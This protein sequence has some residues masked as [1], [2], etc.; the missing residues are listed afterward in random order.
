MK[1]RTNNKLHCVPLF[2][3]FAAIAFSAFLTGCTAKNGGAPGMD[4]TSSSA[5]MGTA[6]RGKYLVTTTGCNDCHTPWTMGPKG[7]GPDM[8]KMLSGHPAGLKMISAPGLQPPWMVAGGMT[9]TSW[10]GPWGIS[11]TANITPDSATGIG[12]WTQDQFISTLKTGKHMGTGRAILPPMP[13]N[14]FSQMTDADLASIYMYLK[15]IPA[16]SNQVPDP[17][18]PSMA[19]Q[20]MP[21]GMQQPPVPPGGMVPPPPP[22]LPNAPVHPQHK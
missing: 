22:P 5:A 20:G 1:I 7:P 16:I 3:A 14:W 4:S 9:M 13:W 19:M 18:P 15:T 2:G 12:K 21:L 17:V 8:T 6:E 10:G 11:Y